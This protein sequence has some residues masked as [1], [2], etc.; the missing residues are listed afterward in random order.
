MAGAWEEWVSHAA[1]GMRASRARVGTYHSRSL[2]GLARVGLGLGGSLLGGGGLLSGSL[3]RGLLGS[4][5][6][7]R[8]GL[9]GRS[10]LFGW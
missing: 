1:N 7:G 5:L 2:A 10:L 3:G 6:L 4:S 8:G 9:G